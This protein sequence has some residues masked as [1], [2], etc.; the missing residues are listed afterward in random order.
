MSSAVSHSNQSHTN[1]FLPCFQSVYLRH[2]IL[3]AWGCD[4]EE[5]W[6]KYGVGGICYNSFLD[7]T[8]TVDRVTTIREYI[9]QYPE[10]MNTE[11]PD[12]LKERYSG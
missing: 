9:D 3:A 7:E 10:V 5:K 11:P 8:Y 12:N 4:S 2:C 6:S 1:S